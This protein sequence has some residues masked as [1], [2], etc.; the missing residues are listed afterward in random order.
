[1][2][3]RMLD[4]CNR[5]NIEPI[6]ELFP[7]KVNEALVHLETGKARDRMVLQ[8]D[9]AEGYLHPIHFLLMCSC[10]CVLCVPMLEIG[11]KEDRLSF[12]FTHIPR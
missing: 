7:L 2:I 12:S 11:Y 4:F 5:H 9:F 6:T 3:L 10:A 1:M 8:N